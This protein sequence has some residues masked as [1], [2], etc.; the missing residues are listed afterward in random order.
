MSYCKPGGSV[1]NYYPL[2]RSCFWLDANK[3]N[4]KL[5]KAKCV[6]TTSS[7]K[8]ARPLDRSWY[9]FRNQYTYDCLRL[10]HQSYPVQVLRQGSGGLQDKDGSADSVKL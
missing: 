8:Q 3:A 4:G 2:R 9:I 7:L 5:L 6:I 1:S 10:E